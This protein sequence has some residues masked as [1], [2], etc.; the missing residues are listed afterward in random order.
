MSLDYDEIV[1]RA[2]PGSPFAN[3]TEGERWEAAWCDRCLHDAPF[4]RMGKGTGCPILMVAVAEMTPAEWLEGPRDDNGR[5]SMDH[6]YTCIEFRPPGGRGGGEPKPKPEPPG[7]EG[8]FERSPRRT[9][10]YVQP[11][12]KIA[13]VSFSR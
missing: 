9:R 11:T 5:Y 13:E 4:R 10:M 6:Q 2:R 12:E 7:M 1:A 3:G 8:L